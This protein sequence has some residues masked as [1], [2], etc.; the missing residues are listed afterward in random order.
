[1]DAFFEELFQE[2]KVEIWYKENYYDTSEGQ[3]A[4]VSKNWKHHKI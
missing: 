4:L 1:M 3:V 2:G